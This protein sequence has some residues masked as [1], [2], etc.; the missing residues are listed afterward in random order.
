MTLTINTNIASIIAERNLNTATNKLNQS[1]ERLS[2]GYTINN[3][4]DNAAGYSIADMWT[5]QISSLDIAAANASMGADL[6]TTAEQTYGLLTTHLQRIRDL[7]V[8]ASNGTFG[9]TSLKAIQSEIHARLK[10][11]SRISANSEYNGIKLMSYA[12]DITGTGMT[13][14]GINLQVGLYAN[15]D[16]T[17]KLDVDLF[18]NASISGLFY[19][20]TITADSVEKEIATYINA[21]ANDVVTLSKYNTE[22][23]YQVLAAACSG[24]KLQSKTDDVYKFVIQ[25]SATLGAEQMIGFIDNA[26]DDISKRV[27][28][29]GS[30]QNRVASAL[31]AIDVQS[32][33]L[34]SSLSTLRD[35]D[36]ANESSKYIQAQILQQASATLLSTANQTPSIALNLI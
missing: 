27:T 21:A 30:A 1:L 33:N 11:I 17:I 14:N 10:E 22:D 2:T 3:A 25:D 4:S 15:T 5:T 24:L 28:K 18:K 20:K 7:A 16:S 12:E 8:Q 23:G 26:I 19:G 35:T 32:Q 9:S 29:I 31:S 34:T 6:L 36:V 13:E